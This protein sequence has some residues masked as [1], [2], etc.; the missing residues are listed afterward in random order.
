M[1]AAHI[2]AAALAGVAGGSVTA[3]ILAMVSRSNSSC[4]V[5]PPGPPGPQG[6]AGLTGKDCECAHSGVRVVSADAQ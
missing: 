2:I 4:L 5:G 6:P 1:N 3:W